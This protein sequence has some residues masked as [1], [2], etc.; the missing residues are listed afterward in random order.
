[1]AAGKLWG[2]EDTN[3]ATWFKAGAML[4]L[5]HKGVMASKILP[6]QSKNM[7]QRLLYHDATKLAF[8]KARELT[9]TTT[10]SKLGAIGGETEKIGLQ[11]LEGID[12][13]F[14]KNSVAQRADNL[15][16]QWQLEINN[17]ITNVSK[18]YSQAEKDLAISIIRGNKAKVSTRV[19]TLATKIEGE[20]IKFKKLMNDA[21][22][23]SLDK[24]GKLMEVKNYFPRVWNYE[25]ITKDL[26]NLKTFL[27][28]FL[29][30]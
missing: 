18:P 28:K 5:T 2:P 16:R 22:I 26:R 1:M 8:Q 21:G 11:L 19:N 6:G 29:K 20:L 4:G 24:K 30:V 12:S 17:I 23:F 27:L 14:A 9:A 3:L 13:T 10:S 15:L 7:I 25:E